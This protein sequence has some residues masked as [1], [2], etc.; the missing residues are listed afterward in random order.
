MPSFSTS[1]MATNIQPV[2]LP[3]SMAIEPGM[4]L[5]MFA[6]LVAHLVFSFIKRLY[7]NFQSTSPRTLELQKSLLWE[8][9]AAVPIYTLE[10]PCFLKFHPSTLLFPRPVFSLTL[11]PSM[12]QILAQILVLVLLDIGFEHV[13]GCWME[14]RIEEK[15]DWNNEGREMK[16]WE[17]GLKFA[18]PRASLLVAITVLGIPWCGTK[19]IGMLHGGS[20]AI[21]TLLL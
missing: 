15:S 7:D 14:E 9:M 21:W 19:W 5:I 10:F 2:S 8:H 13:I 11:Q 12:W 17:L 4:L 16:A 3:A 18:A 6:T 1:T 20:V